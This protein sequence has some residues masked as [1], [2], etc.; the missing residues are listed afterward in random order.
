M[1]STRSI[2]STHDFFSAGLIGLKFA[3]L[4]TTRLIP[5]ASSAI[6]HFHQSPPVSSQSTSPV[7]RGRSEPAA[8]VPVPEA[9]SGGAAHLPAGGPADRSGRHHG[10]AARLLPLQ[11]CGRRRLAR[12]ETGRKKKNLDGC[13]AKRE[14][15]VQRKEEGGLLN[16]VCLKTV[17]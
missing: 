8:A 2:S 7:G 6:P 5:L 12:Y 3:S 1:L 16:V 15:G 14:E 17:H 11:S 13:G 4:L 10:P 9:G